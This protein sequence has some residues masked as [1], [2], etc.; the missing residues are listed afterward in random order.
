[1]QRFVDDH[2]L[3]VDGRTRVVARTV[4]IAT[5][6]RPAGADSFDALGDRVIVSDDVFDWQ[7]LPKSVA[8]I[9]PGIIGLELGQALHR[10]GVRVAILGRGGRVGPIGDPEILAY[11]IGAFK[12]EFTLE[13]DAQIADMRRDA[14]P[15]RNSSHHARW[16]CTGRDF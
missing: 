12:Q 8:V 11:A 6:S 15:H 13:P 1:M 4:V 3:E 16:L 2:A 14:R 7:D 9:G 5:G 10:L